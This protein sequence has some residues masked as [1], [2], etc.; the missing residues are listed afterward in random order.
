MI[1]LKLLNLIGAPVRKIH[2]SLG[3][4]N[5]AIHHSGVRW[6]SVHYFKRLII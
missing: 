5:H 3:E 6:G 4:G 2:G 1:Y